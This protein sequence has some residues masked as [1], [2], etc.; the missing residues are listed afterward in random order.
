MGSRFIPSRLTPGLHSSA[1]SGPEGSN[2]TFG[3]VTNEP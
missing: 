3:Q 2:K 1:V